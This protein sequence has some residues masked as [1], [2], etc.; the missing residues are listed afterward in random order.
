MYHKMSTFRENCGWGVGLEEDQKSE[1]QT[2]MGW[3][4]ILKLSLK[5]N[6]NITSLRSLTL[7]YPK[8]LPV[9]V[10]LLLNF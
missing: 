8:W 2:P 7:P 6:K 1:V 9:K 10:D 4:L 3:Y 5:N